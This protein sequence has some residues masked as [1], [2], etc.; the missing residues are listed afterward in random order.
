MAHPDAIRLRPLAGLARGRLLPGLLPLLLGLPALPT[1]ASAISLVSA[2]RDHSVEVALGGGIWEGS[3]CVSSGGVD[4]DCRAQLGAAGSLAPTLPAQDT[5]VAQVS[6]FPS[7]D[8]VQG[9]ARAGLAAQFP[10]RD[11]GL[12][13]LGQGVSV[14]GRDAV[15][16]G[17]HTTLD[18]SA[19]S[20]SRLVVD[21]SLGLAPGQSLQMTASLDVFGDGVAASLLSGSYSVV[22]LDTGETLASLAVGASE[23]VTLDLGARLGHLLEASFSGRVEVSLPAGFGGG[24]EPLADRDFFH[25]IQAELAL[26]IVPEPASGLLLGLGV[27]ALG[28]LRRRRPGALAGP[29]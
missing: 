4:P 17:F 2:T 8:D 24:A 28:V 3:S 22:D 29:R 1:P 12:F 26:Q 23:P 9:R 19:A 11:P 27:A 16:G 6:S 18:A 14:G 21:T 10:P 20:I 25:A 13:R 7:S 15:P 5:L